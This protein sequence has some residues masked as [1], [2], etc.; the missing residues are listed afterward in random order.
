MREHRIMNINSVY[1]RLLWFLAL[2]RPVR[3]GVTI[4][5]VLWPGPCFYCVFMAV[6]QAHLK[7]MPSPSLF[8]ADIQELSF[9]AEMQSSNRLRFKVHTCTNIYTHAHNWK[10]AKENCQVIY[11]AST[12]IYF[13]GVLRYMT[14]ACR[15]LRCP[16][17]TLTASAST[18]PVPSATH[19]SSHTNLLG[20]LSAGRRTKKS[21][22]FSLLCDDF[23]LYIVCGRNSAPFFSREQS[24]TQHKLR[25]KSIVHLI[26]YI[27]LQFSTCLLITSRFDTTM[28]PLVFADQF[29]QLSAK[30]PSHNIYGLGE[31]VH[32]H[33][34]H[35]INWKT[36][37]IFT[38][39]AFPNGVRNLLIEWMCKW[40]FC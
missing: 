17:N 29:L 34:R 22:E 32:M 19:W 20:C 11:P 33:F 37:P 10:T 30:L 9:H 1:I 6:I 7:R 39:D 2:T 31:H 28:G 16:M 13:C 5:S 25:T 3:H 36:W 35:D 40:L 27:C 38:R 18:R 4:S 26:S 8:G 12:Q 21:C 24:V 15:G 23:S 14:P